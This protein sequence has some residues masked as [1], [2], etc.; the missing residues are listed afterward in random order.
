MIPEGW[1]KKRLSQCAA[2]IISGGTPKIGRDD[3]YGG[4]IPFLKIDD[5]TSSNSLYLDSAKTMITEKAIEET[6]ARLYPTGTVLVTMYGTIGAVGITSKEMSANQAIAAF[7]DLKDTNPEFLAYLLTNEA[8]QLANKSG[9]TTQANIS[10]TILKTYETLVPPLPEQKKIAAILSSVD[11]TI[12]AT[13]AVIDQTY[14]VKQGLLQQ[15]LTRGIGHTRFKQTKIGEIPVEWDVVRL[16]EVFS[17]RKEPGISGLPVMSVTMKD[18]LIERHTLNRRIASELLPE[19]HLRAQKGDLVYNMMRMWQGASGVAWND[20]IVSP[21]YVLCNPSDLILPRFIAQFFKAPSTIR[22][23]HQHSQ[24]ITEDRLRL[25]FHNFA[26]I[27][28]GLPSKIEQEQISDILESIDNEVTSH[29][30]EF[31][32]LQRIKKAMMQDLLTG[33]VRVKLNGDATT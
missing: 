19:K 9:R 32:S 26:E 4:Y 25:Y 16:G 8:I 33:R 17:H 15:L 12:Q 5:I 20:C 10:G 2:K 24:G 11:D 14:R 23:L 3:Y 30:N 6:S 29:K 22:K 1:Q 13:Q 7:L 31:N 18:G 27:V 21:A 28:I